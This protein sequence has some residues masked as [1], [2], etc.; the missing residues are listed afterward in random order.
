[1]EE[2]MEMVEMAMAQEQMM[3]PEGPAPVEGMPP[4]MEQQIPPEESLTMGL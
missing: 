4:E 3:A 2:K 1:M